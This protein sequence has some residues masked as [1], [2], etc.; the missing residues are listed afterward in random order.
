MDSAPFELR[1]LGHT[2][3]V[4]P[5]IGA[6]DANLHTPKRMALLAYLAL[7]TA[8]GYRRRDQIVGLFW[9]ELGQEAARTQLRKALF[10]LRESLGAEA[11]V[12]RGEG[13]VRLDSD[14]VWC[15]AVVLPRLA[16][17]GRWAEALGLYRGEL[18]EGLFAEGVAQQFDEWLSEQR[19]AL[20]EHAATAAWECSRLEEERGDRKA[21]A[22]LARRALELAPDDENGVRR[23]MSL[24]DR[25]G[26]RGGALRVYADWQA[27]LLKEY[28]VEPAPETRKLARRIQSARKG[29]SHETPPTMAPIAVASTPVVAA[30]ATA[31]PLPRSRHAW[32]VLA[33]L[34]AV[35]LIAVAGAA[36]V[37][38]GT[39]APANPLSVA[40]LPLRP[41]GDN[42]LAGVG[43]SVAE[44]LTTALVQAG[45]L[46]VRAASRARDVV[47]RGGDVDRIGRGL[48][49]AWVVD[50]GVQQ[51]P[52]QLR[53]T[54]R[55]VRAV[56]GVA[57]WAGTYDMDAADRLATARRVAAEAGE[58]IRAQLVGV[59]AQDAVRR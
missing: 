20:R 5:G 11:V 53:V 31:N 47:D 13:E 22:V 32:P 46:T 4:G 57:I 6:D 27:R 12:S 54:L 39:T 59:A 8:D 10:A 48:G 3:V 42:A 55:L 56:D 14:H 1:I 38:S 19:R 33:G 58:Q 50:G 18:L 52:G 37:R 41:I 15:D 29:E 23:L 25:Q 17:A 9:P 21:A 36:L 40:V 45:S 28:G 34:A 16:M 24:L 30:A 49:V 2:E 35:L 7:A 51:G 44:E 43:E 26:D